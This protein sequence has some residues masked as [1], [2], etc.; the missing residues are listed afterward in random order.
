MNYED[1]LQRIVEAWA[2]YS[3]CRCDDDLVENMRRH[4]KK[5]L[6]QELGWLTPEQQ[7]QKIKQWEEGK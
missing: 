3:P 2:P 5:K 7:E 4:R 1:R 6:L